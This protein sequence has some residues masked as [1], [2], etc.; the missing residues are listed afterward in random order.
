MGLA[1][2]LVPL[3]DADARN[4]EYMPFRLTQKRL[5]WVTFIIWHP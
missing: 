2:G 3:D 5:S 1:I 4:R